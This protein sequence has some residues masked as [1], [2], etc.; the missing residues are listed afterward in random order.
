[1]IYA[2]KRCYADDAEW[3]RRTE[4]MR[5]S[6]EAKI[7]KHEEDKKALRGPIKKRAWG[8]IWRCKICRTP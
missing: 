7:K 6:L 5:K 2:D 1:M 3:Q 8:M 4:K